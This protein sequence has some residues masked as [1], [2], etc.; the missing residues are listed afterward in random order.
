M[1]RHYIYVLYSTDKFAGLK[2]GIGEPVT[3][4]EEAA[5]LGYSSDRI[6]IYTNSWGPADLGF[7]VGGP[8]KLTNQTLYNGIKNV[9]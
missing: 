5:A 4:S 9:C 3:D 7:V 2:I 8:R 1:N 6:V